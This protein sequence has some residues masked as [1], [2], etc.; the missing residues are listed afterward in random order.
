MSSEGHVTM[1][2][3]LKT[4]RVRAETRLRLGSSCARGS[5]AA[6]LTG[7]LRQGPGSP[8]KAAPS[9]GHRRTTGWPAALQLA[10]LT[11]T[12]SLSTRG[13]KLHRDVRIVF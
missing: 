4:P 12:C 8:R 2:P 3:N 6:Q 13:Q 10:W 11:L 5:H 1:L 9:A 7:D